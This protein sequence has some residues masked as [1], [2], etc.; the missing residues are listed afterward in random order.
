MD[1]KGFAK[2]LKRYKYVV[3]LLI[4]LL[5]FIT[6]VVASSIPDLNSSYPNIYN[7][8]MGIGCSIV[9]TEIITIFILVLLSEEETVHK[10]LNEWGIEKI[11]DERS[12]IRI[13]ENNFPKQK[14]DFIAFGLKHF[15]DAN[16]SKNHIINLL[17]KGLHI[18]ILTATR[19]DSRMD[20]QK[21][22]LVNYAVW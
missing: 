14:L 8:A 13:N 21:D 20:V 1:M 6:I 12:N 7:V 18:Q 3:H 19:M 9:S 22:V 4:G 11:F 17:K 16:S 2:I 5:G 10:E 15:R